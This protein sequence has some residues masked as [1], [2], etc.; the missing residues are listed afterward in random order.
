MTEVLK[1]GYEFVDDYR[2]K[3][4]TV[5]DLLS[6]RTGLARLDLPGLIAGI[7]KSISRTEF[8]K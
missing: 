8:C 2:T 1:P 5:R 3:E 4:M 6:H 7:P